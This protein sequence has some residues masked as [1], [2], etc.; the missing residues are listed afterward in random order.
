MLPRQPAQI[1]WVDGNA[2]ASKSWSRIESLE[3]ERLGLGRVD[4]FPDINSDPLEEHFEFVD[5][6]DVDRPISVLQDLAGFSNLGTADRH[7][8]KLGMF[9]QRLGGL[10]TVRIN[11]T[12]NFGNSV[13]GKIGIPWI[14]AFRAVGQ[15]EI[16]TQLHPRRR[17]QG[18]D[19]V[20]GRARIGSALQHDQLPRT[21]IPGNHLCGRFDVGQVRIA[22]RGERRGNTN[23]DRVSFGQAVH[24]RCRDH[25]FRFDTAG[26]PIPRN[27]LNVALASLQALNLLAV[28]IK[29]D[30][31]EP[32]ID[33]N[34]S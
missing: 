6:R 29:A 1:K 26:N 2:V 16:R 22:T 17:Q 11:T 32:C 5:H 20:P 14:L 28:D 27:V 7:G 3:S 10:Q 15:K 21:E 24:I 13:G 18:Q 8:L 19:D 25:P 9:V 30:G 33:E 12:D 23:Q 4:D 31:R 34:S